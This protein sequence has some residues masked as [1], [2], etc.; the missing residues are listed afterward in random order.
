[1]WKGER[2]RMDMVVLDWNWTYDHRN[3]DFQVRKT[4]DRQIERLGRWKYRGIAVHM[5]ICTVAYGLP[6]YALWEAW[7]SP[8]L[9]L[10]LR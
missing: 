2:P 1:M 5:Q 9:C 8:C 7:V 4:N 3:H 10:L 6:S